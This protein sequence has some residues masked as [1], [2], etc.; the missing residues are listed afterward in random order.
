[1]NSIFGLQGKRALIVGGGLG[2]GRA[3]ARLFAAQ[4]ASVGVVDL[5]TSRAQ[6]VASELQAAGH[7]ACS[8]AADVCQPLE[9]ERAVKAVAAALG[10][11][12]ILV[13][14]VGQA[15][16]HCD[17]A[18]LSPEQ[19]ERTLALNLKQHVYT[20]GAFVRQQRSTNTGGAIVMAASI[21]GVLSAPGRAP[22]GAA[23]AGLMSLTK[24][25]AVECGPLGIRVNGVAPGMVQTDRS[26]KSA[27]VRERTRRTIPMGRIGDQNEIAR[28][29][30]FLA[31]DLSSYV[32]GQ[33][34]VADGGMTI[35]AAYDGP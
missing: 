17:L 7:L 35:L 20:C 21:A 14:I 3:C 26:Q 19:L 32:T 12:D 1:M 15:N 13:N 29:V 30:L 28:V 24:T 2:I 22:Y 27:A 5:N 31:S 11:I 18:D 4:G 16:A 10:G 6:A 25:L 23:K 8:A 33:T 34:L 9:A